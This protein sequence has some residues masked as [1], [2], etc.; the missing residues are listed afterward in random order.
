LN[1]Q[2]KMIFGASYA[3]VVDSLDL[4][5]ALLDNLTH[6]GSTPGRIIAS[7]F[8]Q[9]QFRCRYISLKVWLERSLIVLKPPGQTTLKRAFFSPH[10]AYHPG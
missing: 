9:C 8:L 6:R 3:F 10:P 2:M 1:N 7:S 4:A 5:T